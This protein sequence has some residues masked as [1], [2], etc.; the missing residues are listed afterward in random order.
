VAELSKQLRERIEQAKRVPDGLKQIVLTEQDEHKA[1]QQQ[2][3]AKQRAEGKA[4]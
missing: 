4:S 3:R 2:R 1:K